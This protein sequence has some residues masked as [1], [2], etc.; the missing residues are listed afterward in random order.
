[1]FARFV[2]TLLYVLIYGPEIWWTPLS[3]EFRS[4]L[5]N[6]LDK[7]FRTKRQD[8]QRTRS[9]RLRSE[10][11]REQFINNNNIIIE[12]E[13]IDNLI[14]SSPPKKI[15]DSAHTSEVFKTTE[16]SLYFLIY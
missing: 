9:P 3:V 1:M 16:T 10:S 12:I 2:L 11:G 13:I 7:E 8:K 14:P 15:I 5:E 6:K 4:L